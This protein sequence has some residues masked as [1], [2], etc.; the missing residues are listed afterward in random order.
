MTTPTESRSNRIAALFWL[1]AASCACLAVRYVAAWL[2]VA[3][4]L[5]TGLALA[6]GI[7]VLMV[8]GACCSSEN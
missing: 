7:A 1:S 2:E 8:G 5:S 6:A 4:R 3:P